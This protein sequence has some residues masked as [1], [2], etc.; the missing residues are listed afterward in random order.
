MNNF[1]TEVKQKLNDI[2]DDIASVSWLYCTNPGHNFTRNRKLSFA[3]TMKL[4]IA[5]EGDTVNKEIMEYFNY[6][7]ESAPSQ[8]AFNQQRSHIKPEAFE[9]AFK[10]FVDAYPPTQ[11]YDGYRILACDGSN[12]VYTTNPDNVNDYVTYKTRIGHNYNQLHLNALYDIVNRVF[13]DAIIHPGVK[14]DERAALK[15][16][17]NHYECADPGHTII[18]ADRGYESYNLIAQLLEN[19]LK[20]VL[21]AKDFTSRNSITS[22]YKDEY[23]DTPEFDVIVK[24]FISRSKANE[25]LNNPKVFKYIKPSKNFDYLHLG[26]KPNLYYICFRIVRIKVS[27]DN[28]EC[29]ITNLPDWE[30][31]PNKLKEIYRL[32]WGIETAFRQLKYAVGLTNFHSKKVEYIK[33]EIFA[34]LIVHNFSEIIAS[35]ASIS[36]N[37]KLKNKHNYKIN[38]T[39][40]AKICHRF[41]KL[42]FNTSPPDIIG[43]IQRFLSVDKNTERMFPRP[44][45]GI[46]AVSFLYRVS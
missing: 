21:R 16:M 11:S 44:L 4:I 13:V 43:W 23:P 28:Y 14:S 41:L 2:I 33:Q 32:R 19:N 17:I 3:E 8:S 30:F 22:S 31:P 39:M 42:P 20:F 7:L 45:R 1:P 25:I 26:D 35:H 36:R 38:Y 5:M 37:R 12:I 46:G 10:D 40:A 15:Q 9:V 34:K 29:L 27:D 24:R 18:T 6:D